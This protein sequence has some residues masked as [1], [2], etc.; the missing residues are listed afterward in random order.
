MKRYLIAFIVA[1]LVSVAG[2]AHAA[3][4]EPIYL[5][6]KSKMYDI[7]GSAITATG[8]TD[9]ANGG[10]DCRETTVFI[11]ASGT[12]SIT[13]DIQASYDG[14]NWANMENQVSLS[15]AAVTLYKYTFPW[16]MFRVYFTVTTG[17]IDEVQVFCTQR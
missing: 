15:A 6:N 13:A 10:H 11:K 12:V 17:Q 8:A 2:L 16:P 3:S 7:V 9:T 1:L 5:P 4:V 14:S